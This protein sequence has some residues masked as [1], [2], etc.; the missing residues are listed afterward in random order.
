MSLAESE[1]KLGGTV[2]VRQ[3]DGWVQPD[4]RPDSANR[5]RSG[6]DHRAAACRPAKN[7]GSSST[8]PLR[9]RGSSVAPLLRKRRFGVVQTPLCHTKRAES[10]F[11]LVIDTHRLPSSPASAGLRIT[12]YALRAPKQAAHPQ[13]SRSI[14]TKPAPCYSPGDIPGRK[15]AP[16]RAAGWLGESIPIG[17]G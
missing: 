4:L 7:W 6:N 10:Y 14:D 17:P 15:A 2:A 13:L 5:T 1:R 11:Y 12:H 16:R 8:K 9:P 3:T